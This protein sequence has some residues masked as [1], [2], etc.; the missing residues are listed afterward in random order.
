MI[1]S[2]LIEWLQTLPQDAKIQVL[3]HYGGSGYYNQGG[4][5]YITDFTTKVDYQQWKEE[6]DTSPPEYIYGDHF[7]L[8]KV[9][10]E[11]VLQLGVHNK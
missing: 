7:E 5:C 2:E 3:D 4:D 9:G 6:G 1:V 10:E 8:C 11:N